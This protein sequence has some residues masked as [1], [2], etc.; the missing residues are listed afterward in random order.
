MLAGAVSGLCAAWGQTAAPA[1]IPSTQRGDLKYRTYSNV[2]GNNIRASIFNSGYSGAPREVAESVN[3]EW[4]KNTGRIYISIVGIWIGGEVPDKQGNPLQIVDVFAWRTS[5]DGKSWTMEP[6]PG[7]LNPDL[8]PKRIAKS[9]DPESWPPASQRGWRD[10]WDDPVDPGW[11]GSWNGFFGKNIFNADQEL[12]Y[13]CSDD[14]YSRFDYRPDSTDLSRKGLGLLMDVR[15]FAWSQVLINDALFFIHDIKNDGTQ[16]IPKTS[17]LIF[18]ADYVGGDGTDDQPY[19][20]LQ[21]DIAYLT[22]SDRVGTTPFGGEA[23]GVAGIKY[24]ETP[25]NSVDGIDN[26]GDSDS[27]PGLLSGIQGDPET[28]LPHFTDDD[29]KP[30]NLK[31][32]DKIVLIDL[33][34]FDRT[35]AAYPENGGTV[36]TLGRGILL[37]KE[38]SVLQEDTTANSF[39]EDLDGLIDENYSLHRWRYDEINQNMGPV[40]FI[41]YLSFGIGDVLKRGFI[42]PGTNTPQ[43]YAA[44][45][46]MVDESRDDGFDNDRD[47]NGFNDD[48][49]LDG[50]KATGDPG[51]GDGSPSSGSGTEFPGEPNLD[52]TDLAETDMIGLTSAVQ[53][54]VGDISYNTTP[55]KYFWD[56]FMTPGHF[57][58]PRPT[59]E[60]DT[61]VASGF[62]PMDPGQRQRMAIAVA[63]AAGGQT[64]MEDIRNVTNRLADT[65]KAYEADY[66]FAR[67][68]IQVT[69]KAVPGN[70]QVTLYWDD[71]AERSVDQY[72]A[73]IGGQSADFEGY[74]I[75]RAT[76]PAFL[77]AKLI[78]DGFGVAKLYKPIAQ[79]DL[80]DGI[81]GFDPVGINGIHF[82]L[83][84]ETGIVHSYTDPNVVN[85]QR[86]FYAVTAYDFGFAAAGIAPSETPISVD[87]DL[88]GNIKTGTNVAVVRPEAQAAG[89]LPPE[90]ETFEH[91]AGSATGEISIRIVDPAVIRNGHVY[92]VSFEDTLIAGEDSDTLTT[93]NFSVLDVT[94]RVLRIDK[95]I[96][97]G[98]GDEAPI[99][100]GIQLSLQNEKNVALD[101][102]RSGWR[103]GEVF[104][105]VISPVAFIGVFGERRPNDYRVIVGEAGTGASKDTTIGFYKLPFKSVNFRVI[106][107]VDRQPVPFAFAELDGSD[108]NWSV[109]SNDADNTDIV[110]LLEKNAKGNLVYTWQI[111]MNVKPNGE[112]PKP[113]DTLDVFMKKPFLS[114]DRYRFQMKGSDVSRELARKEMD[115]IRVVPNPYIA[116]VSWEPKNTYASGRGPREIH[117][118]NLP[119]KCTIRIYNVNGVL[120]D[121]LEHE[122][123]LENGTEIWDVLSKENFDISYGIYI[124]HVDAPNVGQKTGTFAII[125]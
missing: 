46:P 82:Y 58:L 76:D 122:S 41:R 84:D 12:F 42:V 21:S 60:Y 47:W 52:K 38:G 92:E 49:G 17:L 57:E 9:D 86:Y 63:I 124:Y 66:Q 79:F 111:Y 18:L 125:K 117:F 99:F 19:I 70:G 59:G 20:D 56:F 119:Q 81:K 45:A 106:N 103:R 75:Y 118:I 26:D 51:E 65:R 8:D 69:L 107:L 15:T 43:S 88:Q 77:D 28:V 4:P 95:S 91:A 44:L 13:R 54:P 22:D 109:D 83:G 110:M 97:L 104:P 80:K 33:E 78:T 16:R 96:L 6:V 108:G 105:F 25:G 31:P 93:K 100:D 5:P 29:F 68:P 115:D 98:T 73:D 67:A 62:F 72:I 40:R 102:I 85:G 112:N 71:I 30:R 11:V 1:H 39:D 34:T 120:I 36:V 27:Y 64:K 116:T 53:I 55:D 94:D 113:G 32:G 101:Q 87:V 89:Y 90:V 121:R 24:L 7:F 114:Y 61:F 35:V 37:P 48:V 14:L 2:D 123:A 23:V 50:V 3:Y 10:K 74:R